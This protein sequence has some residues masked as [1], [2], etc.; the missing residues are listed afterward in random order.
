MKH[1]IAL[2]AFSTFSL[3]AHSQSELALN[4]QS[5]KVEIV[6][7]SIRVKL[8]NT[9]F[10]SYHLVI[11]NVLEIESVKLGTNTFCMAKNQQ[12]FFVLDGKNHLLLTVNSAT[13]NTYNLRSLVKQR[14]RDLGLN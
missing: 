5:K 12:M 8:K 6:S 14:K 4:S 13:H 1:L 10:K 9:S 2:L 11:P 7:K 3:L